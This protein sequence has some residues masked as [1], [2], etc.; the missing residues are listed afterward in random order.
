METHERSP[1]VVS[2]NRV[3]TSTLLAGFPEEKGLRPGVLALVALRLAQI[4]ECP[5]GIE[6]HTIALRKNGEREERLRE[7][8]SWSS[9]VL[10]NR[11]E[12]FA[13]AL[14]ENLTSNP[15][16][17]VTKSLLGDGPRYFSQDEIIRLV[18]VIQAMDDWNVTK[19]E[20]IRARKK[21]KV[22]SIAHNVTT[23]S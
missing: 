17:E 20:A 5:I 14:A 23:S 1:K 4:Q 8:E 19:L 12:R 22:D 13:L 2:E 21:P 15:E 18:L 9:S 7:L 10:F 3:P 11:H 16:G 6:S